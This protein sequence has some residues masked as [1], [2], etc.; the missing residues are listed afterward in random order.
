[1]SDAD[2]QVGS[3]NCAG[4]VPLEGAPALRRWLE[5]TGVRAEVGARAPL[6]ISPELV[7]VDEA[8]GDA[9]RRVLTA[10]ATL[11]FASTRTD[12]R[13]VSGGPPAPL[14]RRAGIEHRSRRGARRRSPG[15]ISLLV[16][17]IVLVVSALVL[18]STF[19]TTRGLDAE[20]S[21]AVT[22]SHGTDVGRSPH[23]RS[24]TVHWRPVR[25]VDFYDVIIWRGGKRVRD[26]WPKSATMTLSAQE[27]PPGTYR[28]FVYPARRHGSGY[29]FGRL[30]GSGT[31]TI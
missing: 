12:R 18:G 7:L 27:L 2:P 26:L 21:A 10:P 6:P 31:L 19:D 15:L 5:S 11:R 9:A 22:A 23:T 14:P 30:V 25:D 4:A 1:M 17:A 3:R 20:P 28:W 24:V 8:L 13:L 16:A 29:R